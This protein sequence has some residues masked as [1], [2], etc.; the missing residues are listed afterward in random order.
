M[1]TFYLSVIRT[2]HLGVATAVRQSHRGHH[3][4]TKYQWVGDARAY[5]QF[6]RP[7]SR[8][9]R[10]Q[11]TRSKTGK[12]YW[13]FWRCCA[14]PLTYH[15]IGWSRISSFWF[16]RILVKF[17]KHCHVIL[18]SMLKTGVHFVVLSL[19]K[20]LWKNSHVCQPQNVKSNK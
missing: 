9:S 13:Y 15:C 14:N 12:E 20:S 8:D 3:M 19:T 2:S 16:T 11:I 5:C 6:I 4:R 10:C 1:W 18:F 7:S 17:T